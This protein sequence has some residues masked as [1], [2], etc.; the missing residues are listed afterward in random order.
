MKVYNKN[1][2][3]D[4]T[5]ESILLA[6]DKFDISIDTLSKISEMDPYIL[7]EYLKYKRNFLDIDL[8]TFSSISTYSMFL[9]KN[10][11]AV[12]DEDERLKSMI[13]SLMGY[14]NFTLKNIALYSELN[15]ND[16]ESFMT[17]TK[18]LS[19]EKKYK[20]S[21]IIMS[22]SNLFFNKLK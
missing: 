6:M 1:D 18:S 13:E 16:I 10:K 15:E 11:F 3:Q 7:D 21:I 22:M 8:K 9:S 19:V 17:D 5:R 12:E 14:Y 4:S 20:L 2:L